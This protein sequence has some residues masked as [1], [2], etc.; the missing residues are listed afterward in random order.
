MI[1]RAH[2]NCSTCKAPHTLRI[3]VGHNSYQD[4]AFKCSKCNEDIQIRMD[5]DYK[6]ISTE[7]KCIEN[8]EIGND[9]GAIINLN[10]ELPI[11]P[12]LM[13]QDGVFPW[14]HFV[15]NHFQLN[16]QSGVKQIDNIKFQDIHMALGGN[17][18]TTD[19][20]LL[21]KKAWS[22]QNN[23]RPDLAIELLTKYKEQTGYKEDIEFSQIL[24]HF[25]SAL[26]IPGKWSLFE[27]VANLISD[28]SKL[29]RIEYKTFKSYYLNELKTEHSERYY[30]IFSQY[31]KHFTDFS[32]V[33][34]YS[35][36]SIPVDE[37]FKV[38][39][40]NF[41]NIKMF[42]GDAFEVITSSFV[43]LACLG[44]IYKG[45][46]FDKFETMNLSKY[47]TIKKANRH[48]PFNDIDC[49][50]ALSHCIDSTI[51]NASHH[52]SMKLD[53]HGDLLYRGT[54]STNWK[55]MPYIKY[56]YMCN[57]IMLS[58]C[59]LQMIELLILF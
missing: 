36:N 13:H 35:K 6:N 12:E 27:N 42:Y 26:T 58:I 2:I 21:L 48:I 30:E 10:P 56:L 16:N 45:R 46:S 53:K 22:L 41:K 11:P 5:V 43:V 15:Q 14:M 37:T 49:L 3:G 50:C 39:Y 17:F 20:W 9:E 24:F 23:Q 33:L 29:H 44:N 54:G 38:S 52:S 32:Q 1:V 8:C 31:F 51:R 34:L 47:I 40:G 28:I 19:A 4:H 7:I 55:S 18:A 57:E 59:S 25:S